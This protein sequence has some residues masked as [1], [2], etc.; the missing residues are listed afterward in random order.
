M[1]YLKSSTKGRR[2]SSLK[3]HSLTI[4]SG[5]ILSREKG[6]HLATSTMFSST[7]QESAKPSIVRNQV[8]EIEAMSLAD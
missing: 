8:D 2:L 3:D 6:N 7:V 1:C 5:K 4:Q